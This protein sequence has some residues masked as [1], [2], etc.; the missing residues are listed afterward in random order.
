MRLRDPPKALT[1][2]KKIGGRDPL[3]GKN[4]NRRKQDGK[5]RRQGEFKGRIA[6]EK[7]RHSRAVQKENSLGGTG[8]A[9]GKGGPLIFRGGSGEGRVRTKGRR[10]KEGKLEWGKQ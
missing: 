9:E 6:P 3:L 10:K 4:R 5:R 7:P 8:G 2:I 1:R